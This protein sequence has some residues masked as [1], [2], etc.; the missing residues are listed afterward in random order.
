MRQR[1]QVVLTGGDRQLLK[2]VADFFVPSSVESHGG[3]LRVR[4]NGPI[5][6]V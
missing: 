1:W 2:D 3:L 4:G 6:K 5:H